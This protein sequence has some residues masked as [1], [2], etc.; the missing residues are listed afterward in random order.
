MSSLHAVRRF[1]MLIALGALLFAGQGDAFTAATLAVG[2]SGATTQ[3]AN[4]A[5]GN[6]PV[7]TDG[8]SIANQNR[9]RIILSAASGQ[10][11]SGAGTLRLWLCDAVLARCVRNQ[12][13]ILAVT[14]SVKRDALFEDLDIGIGADGQRAY[15]EAVSVTSSSGALTVTLQT[16]KAP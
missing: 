13:V 16:W 2:P 1:S 4:S 9:L 11:L 8:I 3:T 5:A 14:E 6:V 10:T 15:V 12:N 7:L